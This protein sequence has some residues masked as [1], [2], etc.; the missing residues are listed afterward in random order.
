[1]TELG[2]KEQF[3][4]PFDNVKSRRGRGGVYDYVT[5]K[6]VADRMNSIFGMNW[7]SEMKSLDTMNG[8]IIIRVGVCA[9]DPVSG[10]D[11]CQEGY[12]GAVIRDGEDPGTAHK[13]AYSKALKD[14][15]KK[16]GVGLH[17]TEADE[18]TSTIPSGFSGRET[19]TPI[20]PVPAQ[21]IPNIPPP[22]GINDSTQQNI[23]VPPAPAVQE[24]APA[25]PVVN[26]PPIPT[27]PV[28]MQ[29]KAPAAPVAPVSPLV[30]E[31]DTVS[32]SPVTNSIPSPPASTPTQAAPVTQNTDP[33]PDDP[34]T[35]NN[36]QEM[37]INNLAR[38]GG[39]EDP[40]QLLKDLLAKEDSGFNRDIK[41]I[42]DLSYTEAVKVIK[43]AKEL[44]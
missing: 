20:P 13:S 30:Q 34:G 18:S 38:L 35:I 7:S 27:A 23:P 31:S 40:E 22:A 2:I 14:A 41:N 1:M 19:A 11:F 9:K 29:K 44:S 36:V 17:L 16:W 28:S 10:E 3:Y 39:V 43:V 24:S 37:A 12:G 33:G 6:N 25:V 21:S 5:W 8:S 42:K 4:A 26:T 32:T 15:C